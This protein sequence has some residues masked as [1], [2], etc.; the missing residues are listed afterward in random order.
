MYHIIA[1]DASSSYS[2]YGWGLVFND[3]SRVLVVDDRGNFVAY[4]SE[5]VPVLYRITSSHNKADA[6]L[7]FKDSEGSFVYAQIIAGGEFL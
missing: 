3:K 5:K 7:N 1:N 4:E 2:G 6:Y